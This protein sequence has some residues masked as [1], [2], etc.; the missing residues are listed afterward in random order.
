MIFKRTNASYITL[1]DKQ[2]PFRFGVSDALELEKHH[3]AS[4][5]DVG[6]CAELL[7]CIYICIDV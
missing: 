6:V 7:L 2:A 1:K 4:E 3:L 5:I